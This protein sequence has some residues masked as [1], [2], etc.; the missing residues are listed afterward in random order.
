MKITKSYICPCC[1]MIYDSES[2]VIACLENNDNCIFV[3][4]KPTKETDCWGRTDI[5]FDRSNDFYRHYE[6][7]MKFYKPE[8][9]DFIK[10][11]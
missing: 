2:E 7:A 9:I 4:L 8:N 10:L 6:T 1:K 5:I 3:G 11:K